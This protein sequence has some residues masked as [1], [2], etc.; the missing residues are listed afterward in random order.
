MKILA[1]ALTLVAGAALAAPE[2]VR[3]PPMSPAEEFKNMFGATYSNYAA[4]RVCGNI[5]VINK[6]KANL[7]RV[8]NYGQ[9]RGTLNQ[10]AKIYKTNPEYF[11][12]QGEEA[13]KRDQYVS[14]GQVEEFVDVLDTI[15]RKFP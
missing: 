4:A 9:Y 3:G 15:T 14:C 8:L 12:K 6:A 11:L 13:Y 7:T 2:I 10:D 1:A 5:K